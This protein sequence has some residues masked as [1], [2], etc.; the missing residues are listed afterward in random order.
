SK[1][2]D[3]ASLVRVGAGADLDLLCLDCP[4]G[5]ALVDVVGPLGVYEYEETVFRRMLSIPLLS[6]IGICV[7]VLASKS[8]VDRSRCAEESDQPVTV[9]CLPGSL[10]LFIAQPV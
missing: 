6:P 9:G 8:I 2:H 3:F 1:T 10:L 7:L 5:A 4:S